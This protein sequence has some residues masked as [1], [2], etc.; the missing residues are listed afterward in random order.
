MAGVTAIERY[1][2]LPIVGSSMQHTQIIMLF[3]VAMGAAVS[4]ADAQGSDWMG[5][6]L[7]SIPPAENADGIAYADRPPA[8]TQPPPN[9]M[10][11]HLGIYEELRDLSYMGSIALDAGPYDNV[12]F[13][14]NG[15]FQGISE[16]TDSN[17]LVI[18]EPGL[19]VFSGTGNNCILGSSGND[20]IM[21]GAGDDIIYGR[22]GVDKIESLGGSNVI[23]GG[24]G[25]D[26]IDGGPGN[27]T[28]YG[29]EGNDNLSG[30]DGN[31]NIHGGD[32]DDV[33]YGD[34][35]ND[36]IYGGKGNDV[37]YGDGWIYLSE[38]DDW[39]YGGPGD[40]KI[41]GGPG[42]DTIIESQDTITI[43]NRI[44]ELETRI[45]E[46]ELMCKVP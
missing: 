42:N 38:G 30:W 3:V 26:M 21:S 44:A 6:P 17:V 32:G 24:P 4:Q 9:I 19:E 7:L 22:D 10:E 14:T 1:F 18:L 25:P 33:I 12:L 11:C 23:H 29:N 16:R 35:H 2:K 20:Y 15:M 46:L 34:A 43:L 41:D 27:D 13:I 45:A 8:D 31:D 28:I 36:T 40:D 39:I 5:Q 37:I